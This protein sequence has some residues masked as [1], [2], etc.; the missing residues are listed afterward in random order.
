MSNTQYQSST[1]TE[2][3]VEQYYKEELSDWF[4]W[5]GF[6]MLVYVTIIA[7]TTMHIFVFSKLLEEG[8][9]TEGIDGLKFAFSLLA[10]V[11]AGFMVWDFAR[12]ISYATIWQTGKHRG[13]LAVG[14]VATIA[15]GVTLNTQG[16]LSEEHA[17]VYANV[18]WAMALLVGL[19]LSRGGIFKE[20]IKRLSGVLS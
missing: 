9:I 5:I 13:Y 18:A 4:G 8:L 14:I 3:T 12:G 1:E 16:D 6:R 2:Q 7:F 20:D 15:A 17:E 11:T 10:V 19:E